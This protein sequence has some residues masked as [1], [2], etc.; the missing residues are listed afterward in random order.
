MNKHTTTTLRLFVAALVIFAFASCSKMDAELPQAPQAAAVAPAADSW[1]TAAGWS[2][3]QL[4]GQTLHSLALT[5][6]ALT[7]Q[8]LK[9]G[10]VLVFARTAENAQVRSL[11][12]SADGQSWYYQASVNSLQIQVE[13]TQGAAP[14]KN[15]LRYFVIPQQKITELKA[16]GYTKA[17]LLQLTY[18]AAQTLLN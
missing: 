18:E 15:Q 9:K 17:Q 7:V 13:S 12:F 11:P 16:Q 1:K 3:S 5:D 10:L 2:T 6:T 14:Q 4:E 8:N